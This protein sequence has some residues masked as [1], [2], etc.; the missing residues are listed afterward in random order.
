MGR[1]TEHGPERKVLHR[2]RSDD[3]SNALK[4]SIQS[5]KSILDVTHE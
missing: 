5:V 3:R 4:G 1:V 2:R